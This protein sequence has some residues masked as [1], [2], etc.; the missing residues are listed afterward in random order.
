MI[1]NIFSTVKSQRSSSS[2]T[3]HLNLYNGVDY[4][5]KYLIN[6]GQKSGLC[7][8]TEHFP[9]D[10]SD[11]CSV[12]KNRIHSRWYIRNVY[13]TQ[14]Q[15]PLTKVH[16]KYRYVLRTETEHFHHATPEMYIVHRNETIS[17]RYNI[18]MYCAEKQNTFQ[19]VHQKYVL[20]TETNLFPCGASEMCTVHTN[21]TRSTR[22]IRNVYCVQKGNNITM[23]NQNSLPC[24][25]T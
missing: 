17:W 16:Q 5:K 22:Y 14:K 24:T 3:K 1:G 9:D 2:N 4:L 13:C 25:E 18:N 10:I 7:T 19:T 6:G 11:T 20:C 21:R 8:E 23:V 15:I 12:H